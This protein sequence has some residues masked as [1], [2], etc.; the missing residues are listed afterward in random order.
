MDDKDHELTNKFPFSIPVQI[1]LW[2][3][4]TTLVGMPSC[5]RVTGSDSSM[6]DKD[7][8]RNGRIA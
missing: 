6:D 5:I 1:P 8:I 7:L 2:T 3:I 4:R